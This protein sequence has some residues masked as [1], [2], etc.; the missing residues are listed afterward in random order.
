MDAAS[1]HQWMAFLLV[2]VTLP[3]ILFADSSSPSML[4]VTIGSSFNYYYYWFIIYLL[5]ML[6]SAF[7]SCLEWIEERVTGC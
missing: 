2:R 6:S 7:S 4:T 3:L 1:T 5:T